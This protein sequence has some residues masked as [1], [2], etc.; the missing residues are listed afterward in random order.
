MA[1]IEEAPGEIDPTSGR[2]NTTIR[3]TRYECNEAMRTLGARLALSGTID[4]ELEYRTEQY[5]TWA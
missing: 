2:G 4:K 3:I 5:N 1:T